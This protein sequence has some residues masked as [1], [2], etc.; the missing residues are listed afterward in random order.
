MVLRRI[1]LVLLFLLAALP[2]WAAVPVVRVVGPSP[3]A[4]EVAGRLAG[5]VP[6]VE[7]RRDGPAQLVVAVGAR[8]FQ[9]AVA[10][11]AG[12]PVVGV[13]LTRR[14]YLQAAAGAQRH[15]ALFWEPDPVQQLRLARVLLPGARKVGIVLGDPDDVLLG[16]VQ[17][18]AERLGFQPVVASLDTPGS[19]SRHLNTVL[20]GSDFLLG[21][22]DPRVFSPEH[23]KTV[24][25]TSY[26]HGKPVVGPNSAFVEAGSVASLSSTVPAMVDSLVAWLP[27]L[28]ADGPLPPPRYVE[29]YPVV[30]NAQVARSL[31]LSLPDASLIEARLYGQGGKP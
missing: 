3:V 28:L 23:A 15:T 22:D 17:R 13:A 31:Q 18:E 25:L 1:A 12:V 14:S 11:S 27:A 5:R 26:R 19:L 9:A 16:A 30:S 7:V 29:R 4:D 2:A 24:L 8:A 21:I 20:S 6:R 10:E